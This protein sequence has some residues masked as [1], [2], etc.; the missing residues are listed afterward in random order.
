MQLKRRMILISMTLC[1]CFSAQAQHSHFFGL[2]YSPA[3]PGGGLSDFTDDFSFRGLNVSGLYLLNPNFSLGFSSGW[4]VFREASDGIVS[5]VI[6]GP[7]RNITLSAKQFR[8]VN[9]L[10]ILATAN[11][12]FQSE[13]F[14]PY[15]G[16]GVGTYYIERRLEM[17]LYAFREDNWH[18]GLAP[19][20]GVAF[21]LGYGA[22]LHLGVQYNQAFAAQSTSA[23]SYTSFKIGFWWD[24]F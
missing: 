9:S 2:S 7:E 10:P 19:M 11:Y 23:M 14:H 15:L 22:F 13:K 24:T 6:K 8:F 5:E 1:L 3:L 21:P 16:L 12:H 20:A 18:A 17:G 4:N